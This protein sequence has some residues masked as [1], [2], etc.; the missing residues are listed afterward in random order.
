MRMRAKVLVN[1][2]KPKE[3]A[4]Q[5]KA[6]R[7]EAGEDKDDETP[8]AKAGRAGDGFE[9]VLYG[10]ES[11]LDDSEDEKEVLAYSRGHADV[12]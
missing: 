12:V 4:K 3:R 11:E 10:R 2:R 6:S 7:V 1:I 5:K 8:K 9:D